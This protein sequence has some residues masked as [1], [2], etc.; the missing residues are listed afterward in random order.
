M[1]FALNAHEL[2]SDITK[3]LWF[4]WLSAK[5]YWNTTHACVHC[6]MFKIVYAHCSIDRKNKTEKIEQNSIRFHS[7]H[8]RCAFSF[9][10]LL[11]WWFIEH[12]LCTNFSL[13]VSLQSVNWII[14]KNYYYR[15]KKMQQFDEF[16]WILSEIWESSIWLP[17]NWQRL[18]YYLL[19]VSGFDFFFLRLN[20]S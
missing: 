5:L 13:S 18:N 4:N 16:L 14:V 15:E 8:K 20:N 19:S 12:S 6:T 7:I 1:S 2:I 3:S 10:F 17:K 11:F 9:I